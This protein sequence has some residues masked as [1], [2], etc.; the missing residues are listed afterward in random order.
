MF[1]ISI[2]S[3]VKCDE[4]KIFKIEKKGEKIVFRV[5]WKNNLNKKNRNRK[6]HREKKRY[7]LSYPA[8]YHYLANSEIFRKSWDRDIDSIVWRF[9][10]FPQFLFF[11]YDS[12]INFPFFFFKFDSFQL[13]GKIIFI[14]V[15]FIVINTFIIFYLSLPFVFFFSFF[16]LRFFWENAETCWEKYN[17]DYDNHFATKIFI[18]WSNAERKNFGSWTVFE[19]F[20]IWRNQKKNGKKRKLSFTVSCKIIFL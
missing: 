4:K 13:I 11:P 20:R 2:N 18:F 9:H 19:K 8:F 7:F 6:F 3:W 10:F 14:S 1:S 5:Q 17:R 16:L 15:D 12:T